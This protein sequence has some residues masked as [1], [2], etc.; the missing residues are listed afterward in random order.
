MRWS[1]RI[2][3]VLSARGRAMGLASARARAGRIGLADADTLRWRA[4]E[5]RRGALVRVVRI[6]APDGSVADWVVRWSVDGRSDQLDVLSGGKVVF[7]GG[8]KQV[9]L[10]IGRKLLAV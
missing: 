10:M 1:R 2:A 9:G 4:L 8:T 3:Q 7:T 6:V 5:D